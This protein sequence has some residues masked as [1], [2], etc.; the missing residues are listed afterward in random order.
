MARWCAAAPLGEL[1]LAVVAHGVAGGRPPGAERVWRE[2]QQELA[3]L[4]ANNRYE[5]AKASGHYIQ[6]DQPELVV[7]LTREVVEV[8]RHGGRLSQS[9]HNPSG[10]T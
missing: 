1:P 10:K 2:L 5:V 6:I 4:S 9:R 7:A 3:G 8:K